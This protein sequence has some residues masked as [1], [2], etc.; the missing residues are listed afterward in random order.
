MSDERLR[1]I[2]ERRAR[3]ALGP[4]DYDRALGEVLAND[5]SVVCTF[6]YGS[7][8]AE[9]VFHARQDIPDLLAE[10]KRLREENERLKEASQADRFL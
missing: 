10:L 2:E 6:P 3:A 1:E 7:E 5:G 4:W 9:F 8:S